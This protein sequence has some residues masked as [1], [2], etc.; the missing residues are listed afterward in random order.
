MSSSR[1]KSP[2]LLVMSSFS[3]SSADLR[4]LRISMA[5]L[6]R[7]S[8]ESATSGRDQDANVLRSTADAA[9]DSMAAALKAPSRFRGK[10][11]QAAAFAALLPTGR[12]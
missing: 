5:R 7:P 8:A 6:L 10:S 4:R 3:L 9:R 1:D 2:E 11:A 12:P